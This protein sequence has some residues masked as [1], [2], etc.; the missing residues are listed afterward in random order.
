MLAF[1]YFYN[2]KIVNLSKWFQPSFKPEK[3]WICLQAFAQGIWTTFRATFVTSFTSKV[4]VS[5][6]LL[7]IVTSAHYCFFSPTSYCSSGY[8]A[9]KL[10]PRGSSEISVPVTSNLSNKNGH[11]LSQPIQKHW[12]IL[13][14]KL[15]KKLIKELKTI[16][17]FM[18]NTIN[19]KK[20]K[21][22]CTTV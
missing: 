20:K 19:K 22:F 12:F 15:H 6:L 8:E 17:S 9:M 13:H 11:N 2:S 4:F 3:S 16:Y 10:H 1:D 5:L 18:T 7:F 21:D 14:R